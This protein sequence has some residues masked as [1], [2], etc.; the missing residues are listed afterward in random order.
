MK[1]KANLCEAFTQR[2]LLH[3][4]QLRAIPTRTSPICTSRVF[5]QLVRV[6]F[7]YIIVVV[8]SLLSPKMLWSAIV[9]NSRQFLFYRQNGV[10][11]DK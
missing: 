3:E 4:S 6:L 9:Q 2:R 11:E 8:F 10:L 5:R 1:S 7:V